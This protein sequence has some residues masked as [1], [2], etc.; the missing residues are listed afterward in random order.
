MTSDDYLMLEKMEQEIAGLEEALLISQ[1]EDCTK[2]I[3]SLR[4][5]LLVLRRYYEQLLAICD[6]IEES[7]NCLLD[8]HVK[9]NFRLF[10]QKVTR[11]E[12]AVNSLRD[13]VTQVR[14]AYQRRWIFA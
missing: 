8:R 11:L 4:K 5:R 12:G 9:R 2:E 14:E 3:I 6:G 10:S 1:K 13:Y 7:E